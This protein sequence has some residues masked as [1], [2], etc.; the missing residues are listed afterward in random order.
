MME[1]YGMQN[2]V[3]AEYVLFNEYFRDCIF[4]YSG[5]M[6]CVVL[7]CEKNVPLMR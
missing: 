2:N 3:Y 1:Q 7:T 6:D 4:W 5:S